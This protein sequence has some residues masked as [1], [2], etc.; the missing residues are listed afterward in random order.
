M[1]NS[2]PYRFITNKDIQEE[3]NDSPFYYA[4]QGNACFNA[5]EMKLLR[6][7][8]D[9]EAQPFV[10]DRERN[11]ANGGGDK[12]SNATH[13]DR[14]SHGVWLGQDKYKWVYDR[15]WPIVLA[16]NKNYKVNIE[17]FEI[18]QIAYYDEKDSGHFD[19]HSDTGPTAMRR[20]LSISIPLSD[21]SE[22][23]GGEIQLN[24]GG[25]LLAPAQVQGKLIIFP[26]WVVHRVTPV[27]K[28]RRYSMVL[29]IHGARWT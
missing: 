11:S 16:V 5:E 3:S 6:D 19:W 28:G 21:P 27:T 25:K 10:V 26:S 29:W 7:L 12:E 13:N 2:P 17:F 22:Y 14:R 9:K 20:K 18:A 24:A 15:V 4:T 1:A 8:A 23:E